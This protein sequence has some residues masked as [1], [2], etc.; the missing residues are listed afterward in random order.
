VIR[1]LCKRCGG[2][3]DFFFDPETNYLEWGCNNPKPMR[4]DE[5]HEREWLKL[6][7][8]EVEY[9]VKITLKGN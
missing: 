1:P 6:S 4:T 7:E 3:L 2:P 8:K 5:E 9:L